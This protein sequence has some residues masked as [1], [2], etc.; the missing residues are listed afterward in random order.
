[1]DPVN[2]R[3]EVAQ[4]AFIAQ[5]S[6]FLSQFISIDLPSQKATCKEFQL[7]EIV[8]ILSPYLSYALTICSFEILWPG[9]MP[10]R[11]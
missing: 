11:R 10:S 6:I 2:E 1:M 8:G 4:D 5:H 7:A 3:R 9:N